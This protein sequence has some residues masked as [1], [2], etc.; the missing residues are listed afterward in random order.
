MKKEDKKEKK[1]GFCEMR[2][3]MKM[4]ES[5]ARKGT[6]EN[7]LKELSF[8]ENKPFKINFN[9]GIS[10]DFKKASLNEEEKKKL[11]PAKMKLKKKFSSSM[12]KKEKGFEK[13]YGK[14]RAAEVRS[15]TAIKM[16]KKK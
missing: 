10:V 3:K 11:S 7:Y 2:K 9:E 14:E 16:A 8:G 12:K 6:I 15:R 5:F 1:C 13:L 4:K